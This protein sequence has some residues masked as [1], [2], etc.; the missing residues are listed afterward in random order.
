[1]VIPDDKYAATEK[2]LGV[3]W[4]PVDDQFRFRV[5]LNFQRERGNCTPNRIWNHTDLREDSCEFNQ[6]EDSFPDQ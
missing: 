4:N 2:V 3:A 1:M 6:T 5:K